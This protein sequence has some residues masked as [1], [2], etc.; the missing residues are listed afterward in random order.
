MD[1]AFSTTCAVISVLTR[2]SSSTFLLMSIL[3]EWVPHLERPCPHSR[4]RR[5]DSTLWSF[6]ACQSLSFS[7]ISCPIIQLSYQIKRHKKAQIFL[8]IALK[9][10]KS[11][12]CPSLPY[13]A[14]VWPILFSPTITNQ[15]NFPKDPVFIHHQ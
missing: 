14:V 10:S 4:G 12:F 7:P 8:K 6:A 3:V 1:P 11:C 2:G 9:L 15:F 13:F 5:F